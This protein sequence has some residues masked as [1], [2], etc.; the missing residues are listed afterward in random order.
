[1]K[2]LNHKLLIVTAAAALSAAGLFAA[3]ET[4]HMGRHGRF[5][6][7]MAAELGLTD[8]QKAQAKIIFQTAHQTAMPVMQQLRQERQAVR[9]A[10]Q[11][12]KSDQEIQQLAQAEGPQL[13]QLA[14]IRA[15]AFAKFYATLTP[16]QQQKLQTLRQSHRGGKSGATNPPSAQ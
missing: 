14:G 1:M 10:A 12:G 3:A 5:G 4:G 7:R 16:D 15:S 13:A 8:A 6:A 11:A 9:A 2:F